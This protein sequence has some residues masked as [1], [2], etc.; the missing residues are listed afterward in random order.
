MHSR[1]S[2]EQAGAV[3]VA[4]LEQHVNGDA[5]FTGEARHGYARLAGAL[6]QLQL[7]L[8]PIVRP[9]LAGACLRAAMVV[10][11]VVCMMV[12]VKL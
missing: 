9:S 6:R 2:A 5:V 3:M 10:V 12:P 4:P 7:E 1:H 11:S 8:G